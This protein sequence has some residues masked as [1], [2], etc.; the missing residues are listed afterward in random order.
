MEVMAVNMPA[1]TAAATRAYS[2]AVAPAVPKRAI[3]FDKEELQFFVNV[4][5]S[6]RRKV[7]GPSPDL[8][9]VR[10]RL[11]TLDHFSAQ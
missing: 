6:Y 11:A 4:L 7:K 10:K 1:D 2:T 9:G 5:T 3:H 8:R